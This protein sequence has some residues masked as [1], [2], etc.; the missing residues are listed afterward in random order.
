[1]ARAINATQDDEEIDDTPKIAASIRNK[2]KQGGPRLVLMEEAEADSLDDELVP[3]SGTVVNGINRYDESPVQGG[4]ILTPQGKLINH[5]GH[6]IE[7]DGTVISPD[8]YR[9]DT[10]FNG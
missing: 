9:T 4:R 6:E 2:T 1:M 3:H 7:Q 10:D 5:R 8:R